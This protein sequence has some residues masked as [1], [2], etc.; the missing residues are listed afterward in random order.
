MLDADVP[1]TA[2]FQADLI[3]Q[4][5][6]NLRWFIHGLPDRETK[7][8]VSSLAD[9]LVPDEFKP[10]GQVPAWAHRRLLKLYRRTPEFI[11]QQFI[12]GEYHVCFWK[13]PPI[14]F[15]EPTRL[16]SPE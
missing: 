16:T 2:T 11:G 5:A 15:G 10:G 13:G 9:A 4:A 12:S 3:K 6:K 8:P 14:A 1:Q 7:V